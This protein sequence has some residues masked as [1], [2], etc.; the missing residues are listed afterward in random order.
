MNLC[1][2]SIFKNFDLN[3]FIFVCL[4]CNFINGEDVVC[5]VLYWLVGDV[6]FGC[7]LFMLD[8]GLLVYFGGIVVCLLCFLLYDVVSDEYRLNKKVC[9]LVYVF[10]LCLFGYMKD[11]FCWCF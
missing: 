1:F 2:E 10:D 8:F 4:K 3:L 11:I 5:K 9:F 7:L 6:N